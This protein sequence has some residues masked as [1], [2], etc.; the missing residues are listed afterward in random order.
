MLAQRVE[1]TYRDASTTTTTLTQWSMAQFSAH[2]Q[3]KGWVFDLASPGLLSVVMLRFQAW[4]ELHRDPGP[5]PAFDA[6]DAT[7]DSV[8]PI[9]D[10]APVD[11]TPPATSAG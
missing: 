6:W 5:R 11:P 2:C 9:E 10:P 8:D 4:C 7:V 3:A 1:V